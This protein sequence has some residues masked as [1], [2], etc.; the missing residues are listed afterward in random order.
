MSIESAKRKYASANGSRNQ[1]G[2]RKYREIWIVRT[3]SRANAETVRDSALLPAM[4]ASYESGDDAILIEK[5][6]EEIEANVWEVECRYSSRHGPDAKDD[7]TDEQPRIACSSAKYQKAAVKD[8]EGK[9]FLNSAGDPFDPP[10]M[11]EETHFVLT[12][13]RNE[14]SYSAVQAFAYINSINNA[15]WLGA[16]KGEVKMERYAGVKKY[17]NDD[18]YWEVTREFHWNPEGWDPLLVLD[19]GPRFINVDG[20]LVWAEDDYGVQSTALIR[21]NGGGGKLD[22]DD[23]SQ[24]MEFKMYKE[25]DFSVFNITI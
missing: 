8:L 1:T 18:I 12:H 11:F 6:A 17:A 16:G 19:A 2:E 20:D 10:P 25:M 24:W 23:E 5:D 14:V 3:S 13:V 22:K 7:P 9:A 4:G 15:A 21:L